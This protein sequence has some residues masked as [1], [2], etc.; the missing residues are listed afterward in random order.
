MIFKLFKKM[1]GE[2]PMTPM[3]LRGVAISGEFQI[4]TNSRRRARE[5]TQANQQKEYYQISM[6]GKGYRVENDGAGRHF[7]LSSDQWALKSRSTDL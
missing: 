1:A 2:E 4:G 5:R 3:R 7:G 6:S